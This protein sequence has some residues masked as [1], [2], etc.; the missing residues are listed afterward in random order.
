MGLA[1]VHGIVKNHEGFITLY[2]EVGKGTTFHVFLPQVQGKEEPKVASL[3]P[4]PTG[5]ERILLVDDEEIQV[6][7]VQNML[8]RLGYRVI[9]KTDA[10][11]ALEVFRA[12]PDAFDLVITDQTMPHLTGEKLAQELLV[13]RPDLPIILSTGFSEVI[14]EEEAKALGIREF[15]MKPLTV[16]DM[17]VRIRRALG[18]K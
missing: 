8:E 16:R 7:S 4:I 1:V 17:A 11:E 14:H 12:Q 13:I 10:R 5:K 9:G 3:S 15:A 18:K 2:S 6:R